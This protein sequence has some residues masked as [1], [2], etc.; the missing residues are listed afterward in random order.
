MKLISAA[1]LAFA[2]VNKAEVQDPCN[3]DTCREELCYKTYWADGAQDEA[4]LA[5]YEACFGGLLEMEGHKYNHIVRMIYSKMT[6]N[7]QPRDIFR[8]LQNYGCHC[9]P[10]QTRSAGGSGPA[11][12]AQDSLCKSLA[13]CHKCVSL[14]FPGELDVNES[15]YKWK[16]LDGELNCDGNDKKSAAKK[17]LCQ[18]DSDFANKFAAQWDDSTYNEWYWLY[19][20]MMKKPDHKQTP[21]FD[22]AA[23]CVADPNSG[24]GA[25]SCCGASYPEKQ[26]FNSANKACCENTAIFN[27]LTSECCTGG[28]VAAPGDC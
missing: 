5:D 16:M 21:V 3:T 28:V 8:R 7:Y 20:K 12:D 22:A 26:P 14:D 13:R 6:T 4:A 15:K 19:P 9:F 11:V 10:G 25:D 23:T 1:A 27:P 17:A 2:A 24:V 18:C